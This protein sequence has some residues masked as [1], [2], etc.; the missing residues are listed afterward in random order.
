MQGHCDCRRIFDGPPFGGSRE[1][2][3]SCGSKPAKLRTSKC[4]P[5]CPGLRTFVG[6]DGRSPP[7]QELTHAPL[8]GLEVDDQLEL[9]GLHDGLVRRFGFGP[10][11]DSADI[12]A[13]LTMCNP[14]G[15][16]L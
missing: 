8:S 14:A 3:V 16:F 1:P 15:L 11:E 5:V 2:N 4:F 13:G 10:P 9:R 6:V 7:G 12:D